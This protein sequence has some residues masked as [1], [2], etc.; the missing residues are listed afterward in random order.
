MPIPY[1]SICFEN[2]NQM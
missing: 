2:L 1:F